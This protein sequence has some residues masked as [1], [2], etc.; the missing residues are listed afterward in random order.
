MLDK[1]LYRKITKVAYSENRP[2][3]RVVSDMLRKY[4]DVFC[5]LRKIGLVHVTKDT[6]KMIFQHI[7]DE[8]II[9]HAKSLSKRYM[10]VITLLNKNRTL[11]EYL[12]FFK[13]YASASGYQVEVMNANQSGSMKIIIKLNLGRKYSLYLGECFRILLSQVSRVDNSEFTDSVVFFECTP[14]VS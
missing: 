2:V 7:S 5:P 4:I 11:E 14:G 3:E 12:D 6:V 10:E 9:E 1:N 13:L 8:L